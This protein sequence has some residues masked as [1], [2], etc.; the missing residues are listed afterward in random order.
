MNE[1]DVMEERKE[2][3]IDVRIG[4]L[5]FIQVLKEMSL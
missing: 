4:M 1:R 3:E 5:I 2:K